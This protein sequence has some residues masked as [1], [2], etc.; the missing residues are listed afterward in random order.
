MS[1][2][3][4]FPALYGDRFEKVIRE[5]F[6][7][8]ENTFSYENV[9]VIKADGVTA[10]MVLRYDLKTSTRQRNNTGMLMFKHMGRK[11]LPRLKHM[12]WVDSVLVKMDEGTLYVSNMTVYPQFRQRGLATR[13]LRHCE[14]LARKTG[15]KRI[16]LDVEPSHELA[17]QLYRSFGLHVVGEPKRTTIGRQKFEFLRMEKEV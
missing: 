8:P 5:M 11:M 12:L 7:C 2:P 14:D 13:M 17:M 4:F 15:N 16:A 10:G 9:D 3:E 6:S 1:A